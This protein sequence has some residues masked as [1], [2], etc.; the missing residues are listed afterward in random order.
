MNY[1]SVTETEKCLVQPIAT[2]NLLEE[3][4]KLIRRATLRVS[5]AVFDL[6]RIP[7]VVMRRAGECEVITIFINRIDF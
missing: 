1:C 6:G 5:H 2:S 3:E 4:R 7:R